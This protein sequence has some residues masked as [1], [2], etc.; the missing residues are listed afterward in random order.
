[1]LRHLHKLQTR[2]FVA[3]QRRGDIYSL[4]VHTH[5]LGRALLTLARN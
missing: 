1:L 2:G 3:H 4:V 5:P